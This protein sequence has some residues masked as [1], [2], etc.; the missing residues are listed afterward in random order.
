[1]SGELS[2]EELNALVRAYMPRRWAQDVNRIRN[3]PTWGMGPLEQLREAHERYAELLRA[4][5]AAVAE[6]RLNSDVSPLV[7]REIELAI[8][9]EARRLLELADEAVDKNVAEVLSDVREGLDRVL[10]RDDDA[11]YQAY[12]ARRWPQYERLL[13]GGATLAELPVERR[14]DVRILRES[15]PAWRQTRGPVQDDEVQ[16]AKV[17]LDAADE[18][19]QSDTE[20][21]LR[22]Q[23]AEVEAGHNRMKA[24]SAQV[25]LAL[26]DVAD[27]RS[28]NTAIP[29][30][31]AKAGDPA[32][33]E[34]TP[35]E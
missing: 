34:V 4:V 23:A 33:V 11:A 15:Y 7:R 29:V 14:R 17:L 28:G 1:M 27:G 12:A 9:A 10:E 19:F 2:R 24:A 20:R 31:S 3:Y 5:Q 32:V 18:P 21:K 6:V 22:A 13:D 35:P 26:G 8:V 30:W 25:A 16:A